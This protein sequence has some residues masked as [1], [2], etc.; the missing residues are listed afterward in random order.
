MRGSRSAKGAER[1]QALPRKLPGTPW[2]E[3]CGPGGAAACA[4]RPPA[5]AL[6]PK[7]V[8]RDSRVTESD[9]TRTFVQFYE[10]FVD[11]SYADEF[12]EAV[13]PAGDVKRLVLQAERR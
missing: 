11:A 8:V 12:L 5:S 4:V 13:W 3:R 7:D 2:A 10:T 9:H 6:R 1:A